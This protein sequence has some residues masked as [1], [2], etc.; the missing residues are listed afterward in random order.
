MTKTEATSQRRPGPFRVAAGGLLS[1]D[2]TGITSAFVVTIV[3]FSI[4][5][6]YFF[7]LANAGNILGATAYLGITAAMTTML[8]VGG[9]FDLSVAAVM[10]LAGVTAGQLVNSGIPWWIAMIAALVVGGVVGTINGYFVTYIGI[11]ALI[12]TIGTQFLAR[13]LAFIVAGGRELQINTPEFLF[14]GQGRIWGM[15]VAG[16]LMLLTFL[17]VTLIMTF[18]KFGRHVYAIGGNAASARLSGVDVNRRRMQL[19]VF[20]GIIA[21]VSGL[22]LAGYSASGLAY[23]GMGIELQIVAAVI[24]GGTSL[25]GGKGS[26]IG[27]LIGVLFIGAI[28][29]G[30]VL[31]GVPSYYQYVFQGAA[32]LIAVAVDDIRRTREARR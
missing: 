7:Q 14:I 8:M 26:A 11:N 5:S 20:S 3:V 15:P 30:M 1:N 9:G 19:F 6:P 32:L 13:G 23:A 28:L 21:A 4:L 17:V 27:T 31:L 18:T 2:L 12:V 10:A 29:N 16:L 24:L 25:F 22:V